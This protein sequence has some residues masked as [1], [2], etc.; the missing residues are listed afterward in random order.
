MHPL[1]TCAARRTIKKFLQTFT[2]RNFSIT[3][4][5][6]HTPSFCSLSFIVSGR[7]AVSAIFYASFKIIPSTLFAASC[8]SALLSA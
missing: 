1:E 4:R 3:A 7:N 2:R 8:S 5:K 6:R